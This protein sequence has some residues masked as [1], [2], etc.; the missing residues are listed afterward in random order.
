MSRRTCMNCRSQSLELFMDLGDQPNGNLFPDSS[1][2]DTEDSYPFVMAVCTNCWQVQLEEFPSVA[3]MFSDHPYITGLNA[4]VVQHFEE[5]SK[6][7]INKFNIP[8][9]SLVL[10][11]GA[12]DGTLLSKFRDLNME[13]LGMDPGNLSFELAR[14][15]GI[16][17]VQSF[18]N[19]ESARE[20]KNRGVQPDLITATAVFYH[21]EDIHDFVQGLDLI[22]ND[23]T[24][25][26]TQCVYSKELIENLQFDHF[27]HE[28][29]L[30]HAVNPLKRLF[31]MY[32][33]RILDVDTVPIH[34][35]SFVMYVAKEHSPFLSSP[36]VN[37]MIEAEKRFGLEN[38]KT[39][40][41]FSERVEKN[42]VDMLQ[43]LNKL[44]A[45]GK[46]VHGIGAPL[47]GSTLL[48]YYEIGP[49]LVQR[50]VEVNPHKIGRYTPGTHIPIVSEAEEVERPDYYLI[51][52]W[53]FIDFFTKKY[54]D[55]LKGGGK[56]IVP[57]PAINI[58][59][60]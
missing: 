5:L 14:Q 36:K 58:I 11:I 57:H 35:G 33:L 46:T 56:F 15:K 53:N 34:G 22:M 55:F 44:A 51:L 1:E 3:K 40:H 29:T 6:A 59:E 43:L 38:L 50:I 25:F 24:I 12:N 37:E 23:R 27:Y 20:L 10:D 7:I 19:R 48:N 45:E 32:G 42:K 52:A 28:H 2:V 9:H 30:I 4:P 13:V 47:K 31:A 41:T 16:E 21:L 49:D 39:Y 18:W 26:C 17:I 60:Q 54:A 8:E